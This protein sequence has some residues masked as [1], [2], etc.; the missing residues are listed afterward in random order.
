M[1]QVKTY[2]LVQNECV[3]ENV[4]DVATVC[5]HRFNGITPPNDSSGDVAKIPIAIIAGDS[6]EWKQ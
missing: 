6:A 1:Y 5:N 3:G 4:S 2:K